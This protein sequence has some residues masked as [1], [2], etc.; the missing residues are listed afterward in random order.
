MKQQGAPI[1]WID[2]FNPIVVELG[3]IG[4]SARAKNPNAAKLF[5][6]YVISR[7]GQLIVRGGKRNPRNASRNDVEPLIPK[8]DQSRLKSKRVPDEVETNLAQ[9]AREYR[10]IFRVK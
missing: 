9:Y 2:T 3:G 10:D 1:E 5:I 7:E 8:M 4:L 6:D